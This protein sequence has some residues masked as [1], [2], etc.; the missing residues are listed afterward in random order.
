MLPLFHLL[1]LGLSHTAALG[2]RIRREGRGGGEGDVQ[3][4]RNYIDS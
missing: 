2:Q 3:E 4:G 1:S